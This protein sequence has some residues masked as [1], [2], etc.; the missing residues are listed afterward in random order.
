VRPVHSRHYC[1]ELPAA[2]ANRLFVQ[3]FS[4]S[5]RINLFKK[6]EA[7]NSIIIKS[8]LSRLP[9]NKVIG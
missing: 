4:P 2:A 1:A 5:S 7:V 3:K 8:R 9:L 6:R